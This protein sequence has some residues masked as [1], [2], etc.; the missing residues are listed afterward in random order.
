MSAPMRMTNM[1]TDLVSIIL[2]RSTLDTYTLEH[3]GIT[4]DD[5][6]PRIP[7]ERRTM[8]KALRDLADAFDEQAERQVD[9]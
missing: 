3:L 7:L 1:P 2:V 4:P 6:E 8:A 9:A 5:G